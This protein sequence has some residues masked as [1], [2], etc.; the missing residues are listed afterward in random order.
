ME[1]LSPTFIRT[2]KITR[3]NIIFTVQYFLTEVKIWFG[4]CVS[5]GKSEIVEQWKV[6]VPMY[7]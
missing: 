6:I 4:I 1:V 7:N 3:K 2:P 5:G